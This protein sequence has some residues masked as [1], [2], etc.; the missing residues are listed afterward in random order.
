MLS[1]FLDYALAAK[2]AELTHDNLRLQL[3]LEAKILECDLQGEVIV[4]LQNHVKELLALQ[5]LRAKAFEERREPAKA[6]K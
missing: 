6:I 1:W 5:Q 2:N 4:T 3:A